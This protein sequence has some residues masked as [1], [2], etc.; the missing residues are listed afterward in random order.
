MRITWANQ[1]AAD[2]L[3]I[4]PGDMVGQQCHQLWYKRE[5]PCADCPVRKA[6]Q[7][8]EIQQTEVVGP[9][10]SVWFVQGQAQRDSQGNIAGGLEVAVRKARKPQN[11]NSTK[12][13]SVWAAVV[14]STGDAIFTTALDGTIEHWNP[15]AEQVYG[16]SAEEIIGRDI[17]TLADGERK[18]ELIEAVALA[19]QGERIQQF[20]TVN[21]TKQNRQIHI[22]LTMCPVMRPGGRVRSISVTARDVSENVA[23][24]EELINLS[25]V[26]ALTGLNNR[27]GFYHL[28]SQ[29]LKVA[30]RT[31]NSALLIFADID[32][33]KWINDTL[34]HKAGD[35]ALIEAADVL[36]DTFRESDILGRIGGDEFAVLAI[37]VDPA[38]SEDI[39]ER[40]QNT[41][42]LRNAETARKYELALSLG[43]VTC[44][45][46]RN[47]ALEDLMAEADER[48][49]EHKRSKTHCRL[50]R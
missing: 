42:E 8:G 38:E 7:S 5:V 48:M 43:I 11:R 24:R 4:A 16:Y 31:D 17:A 22:A 47:A 44:H 45:P 23:L 32:R 18:D 50:P 13:G 9:D 25:L 2:T 14:E 26:D 34:G 3:D 39:L 28:A 37:E 30:R 10:G 12:D 49:Y 15:G 20:E 33:M 35:G 27:R 21:L 29:Q 41:V 36:R 46:D 19:A 6:M 40:L 1:V